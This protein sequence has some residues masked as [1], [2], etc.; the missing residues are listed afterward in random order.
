MYPGG[1]PGGMGNQNQAGSPIAQV[2]KGVRQSAQSILKDYV[3]AMKP[4]SS[5]DIASLNAGL[6]KHRVYYNR[7]TLEDKAYTLLIRAFTA[8]YSGDSKSAIKYAKKAATVGSKL[9]L[10]VG[11]PTQ[12]YWAVSTSVIISEI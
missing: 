10:S 2:A 9:L 3:A 1:M 7:L 5:Q 8:H 6:K 4:L 11:D 12:M